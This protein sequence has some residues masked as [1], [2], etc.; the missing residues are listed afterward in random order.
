MNCP[1]DDRIG[2]AAQQPM[3]VSRTPGLHLVHPNRAYVYQPAFPVRTQT[4][5][6]LAGEAE[7][8]RSHPLRRGVE[9]SQQVIRHAVPER[10]AS[11][12][13]A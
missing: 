6:G 8:R 9:S 4:E 5:K 12:Q 7:R 11:C 13:N 3:Q 1:Y 10:R 2:S